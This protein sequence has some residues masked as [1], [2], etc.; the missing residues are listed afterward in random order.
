MKPGLLVRWV[1]PQADGRI[2]Q[3]PA[4][5]LLRFDARGDW[6]VV[7]VSGKVANY[8]HALHELID[9]DH[10]DFRTL[11]LPFAALLRADMVETIPNGAIK[12][13]LGEVSFTT[14]SRLRRRLASRLMDEGDLVG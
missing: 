1:F 10:V 3:R 9:L 13:V 4:V 2:K 6:L 7:A 12:D 8:D 11:G 5:L 14:V